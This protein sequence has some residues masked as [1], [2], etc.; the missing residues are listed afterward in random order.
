MMGRGECY[1]TWQ[2][3]TGKEGWPV[4]SSPFIRHYWPPQG[5]TGISVSTWITGG[6]A[7][8]NIWT[9]TQLRKL[10][11]VWSL[12]STF[13]VSFFTPKSLLHLRRHMGEK[14]KKKK[15]G[16]WVKCWWPTPIILAT[17][18]AKIRRIMVWSQPRQIVLETWSR[19]NTKQGW[20]S[21]SSGRTP[22]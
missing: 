12:F 4:P 11:L 8:T 20:W 17:Q 14:K 1:H 21:G 10:I 5:C 6:G 3:T 15:E 13:K 2:Q 16:T 7:H 22:A 18:Q 9:V 19:S